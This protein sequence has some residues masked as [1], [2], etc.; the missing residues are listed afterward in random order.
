MPDTSLVRVKIEL[1]LINRF[2]SSGESLFIAGEGGDHLFMCPPAIESL[3]DSFLDRNFSGFFQKSKELSSIHRVH[4]WRILKVFIKNMFYYYNK[5]YPYGLDK[6]S[7]TWFSEKLLEHVKLLKTFSHPC[8]QTDE[9]FGLQPGKFFQI[10]AL[11]HALASV[12]GSMRGQY[13]SYPLLSQ[14]I[15][16]LALSIPTYLMYN[17]T[18][19]RFLFRKSISDYFNTDN[20]WRKSKGEVTGVNQLGIKENKTYI[21]EKC[22]EGY[23]SKNKFI[24]KDYLKQ[25]IELSCLGQYSGQSIMNLVALESFVEAW[26]DF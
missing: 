12:S 20:V 9:K 18:H 2:M 16:E 23:L 24:N 21:L 19:D 22:L 10:E 26:K 3:C 13:V 5:R 14:P 15:A 8:Y 4:I 25:C 6:L 7:E 17:K 1:D 11:F